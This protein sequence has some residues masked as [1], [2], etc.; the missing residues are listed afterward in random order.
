M[1]PVIFIGGAGD[2]GSG[3]VKNYAAQFARDNRDLI[4]QYFTHDQ[5]DNVIAYINGLDPSAPVSVVGHSWGGDTAMEVAN[6][7]PGRISVLVT[8]DPVGSG[9]TSFL[10]S[11]GQNVGLWINVNAVGGSS[12]DGGNFV[13]GGLA[14]LYGGGAYNNNPRPYADMFLTLNNTHGDFSG[15]MNGVGHWI[16]PVRNVLTGQVGND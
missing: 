3:I 12:F 1:D 6:A 8:I 14:A 5:G 2:S 9:G 15:M 16:G 4:V 11:V 13:A 10:R 7:L